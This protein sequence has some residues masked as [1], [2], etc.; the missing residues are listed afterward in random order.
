MYLYGGGEKKRR[1]WENPK[2]IVL[3]IAG[4][5]KMTLK[6]YVVLLNS[7]RRVGGYCSKI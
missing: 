7:R 5:K 3:V 6:C 2:K 4:R 1:D